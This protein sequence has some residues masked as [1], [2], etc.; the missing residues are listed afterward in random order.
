M[1]TNNALTSAAGWVGLYDGGL[2]PRGYRA[3]AR[4]GLEDGVVAVMAAMT[5]TIEESNDGDDVVSVGW[6]RTRGQLGLDAGEITERVAAAKR[7]TLEGA[8]R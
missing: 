1:T 8:T 6:A 7:G 2:S 4:Q 5:A 3:G